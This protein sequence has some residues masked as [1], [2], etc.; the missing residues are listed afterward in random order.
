MLT[1]HYTFLIRG[2]KSGKKSS[3][4]DKKFPEADDSGTLIAADGTDGGIS[5]LLQDNGGAEG[6]KGKKKGKVWGTQED[7]NNEN[8]IYNSMIFVLIILH[9]VRT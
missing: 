9:T 3:K 7:I 1:V 6:T 4:D 2:K 5:G 8:M